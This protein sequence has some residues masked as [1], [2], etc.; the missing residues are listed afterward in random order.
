MF[1]TYFLYVVVGL[2]LFLGQVF[3]QTSAELSGVVKDETGAV[4]PGVNIAV[5]EVGTGATRTVQTDSQGRYV[6]LELTPGSYQIEASLTGFQTVLRKGIELTVGRHALVDVDMTVGAVQQQVVVTGEA[7]L[8]E[9][10]SSTMA[11]LVNDTQIKDLPLN[12]RN[13]VQLSLLESGVVWARNVG[14][15]SLNGSG[16]KMTFHGARPDYNNFMMDGTSI[17]GNTSSIGG[18]SDSALGVDTIREFQVLTSNYSAEFGRSA[19]GIINIVT[20]SGTNEWHGSAFEFLRNSA[21]DSRNF[22]DPASAPPFKRNQF[23]FTLGGP[24]K[25]DRTF[26]FGGY[27]GLRQS[28]GQSLLSTVPT[29]AARLGN[30]PTGVVT[31][32][33]AVKPYLDLWP[34]PNGRDFGDGTGEFRRSDKDDTRQDFVQGRLD[35]NFSDTDSFFVRYTIDDSVRHTPRLI[36]TWIQNTSIRNQ[37]VTIQERK[38]L[39]PTMLNT[40]RLGFNRSKSNY[41]EEALDSRIMNPSLFFI[42]NS[43]TPGVGPLGVS[44]LTEIGYT[45]NWPQFRVDNVYQVTDTFMLNRGRHALKFGADLQR[46]QSNENM[47]FE[48]SL[49]SFASLRNFLVAQP[50]QFRAVTGDSDWVRGY[51]QSLVGFFAQDDVRIRQSLTLNLGVRWEFSTNP[52]EV[53]GKASHINNPLVDTTVVVGNPWVKLPKDIIAPRFGFAWTPFGNGKTSIRGG[54]GLFHEA[55]LRYYYSDSRILP[56]FIRTI[57]GTAPAVTFPHPTVD[58]NAPTPKIQPMPYEGFKTPYT[59]QYNLAVQSELMLGT[60]LTLGFVGSRGLHISFNRDLNNALPTILP[61]GRFFHGP[62]LQRRNPAWGEQRYKDFNGDSYY[63]AFQMSLRRPMSHG[64]QVQGS[65]TFSRSVDTSSVQSAIP[66]QNPDDVAAERGLSDFDARHVFTSNF[67]Y[68][69]PFQNLTGVSRWLIGGWELNGIVS[70]STGMPFTVTESAGLDIDRDRVVGNTNRPNLISGKTNNPVLG[71]PDRYFDT[72]SFELQQA[73]FYGNLGRNTVIGPGLA[74]LDAGLQK[75][76]P[77]RE[78]VDLQFR[79]EAFNLLNR[80]NFALPTSL[81]FTALNGIPNGS[82]GRIRSTV[83]TSRQLQFSLKLTF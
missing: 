57:S 26:V 37:Y 28:L 12:G 46:I 39:S 79:S 30:L 82:A 68:D 3:A 61:D 11:G 70:L 51:R 35:Q 15:S 45:S 52:T 53:N 71:G 76:F 27:E 56:P 54:F 41:V 29:A 18:A 32:E 25:K 67:I 23:G 6:V 10:T 31:V 73:G 62:G 83:T 19:G 4:M 66:T 22:F 5:K 42:P 14:S 38:I 81:V 13:F 1:R 8:I 47:K 36:P 24:A 58:P 40:F 48:A 55:V 64:L 60:V 77:L 20:K 49:Y 44:S 16:V 63:H 74:T 50:A 69:L 59:M 7:P 9:T 43:S 17:N 65:Y 75:R 21:I 78:K 72:S 2:F 34:L 80:P 33:P